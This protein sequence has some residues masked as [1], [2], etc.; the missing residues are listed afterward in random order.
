MRRATRK[1]RQAPNGKAEAMTALVMHAS[2]KNSIFSTMSAH[3]LG[4]EDERVASYGAVDEVS[5]YLAPLQLLSSLRVLMCRSAPY[6]ARRNN[7]NC[8]YQ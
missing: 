1:S 5:V 2:K 3:S 7:H 6:I 8:L 4:S